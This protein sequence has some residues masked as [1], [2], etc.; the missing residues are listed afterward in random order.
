MLQIPTS[1]VIATAAWI[2]RLAYLIALIGVVAS[3][4]TQ[5]DLLESY[6]VGGFAWVIPWTVDLLAVCAALALQLPGLDRASRWIAGTALTLTV[7]VSVTAN[8]AGAGNPIAKAAHAWPVIA[9]LI[10][11]EAGRDEERTKR[12]KGLQAQAALA[13]AVVLFNERAARQRRHLRSVD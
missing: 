11:K 8:M 9:Y 1:H 2:K 13:E 4:F 12:R 3:Y 6:G 7:G 10:G 5:V